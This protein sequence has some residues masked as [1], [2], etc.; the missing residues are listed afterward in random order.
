M[1]SCTFPLADKYPLAR[2]ASPSAIGPQTEEE[3]GLQALIE[4][5]LQAGP[6][7]D[8]AIDD[9]ASQLRERI[10]NRA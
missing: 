4:E 2:E 6:S 7:I 5:G 9:L 1:T 10:R 8:I 3:Q